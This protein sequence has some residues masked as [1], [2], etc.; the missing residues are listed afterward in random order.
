MRKKILCDKCIHH[1]AIAGSYCILQQES[2]NIC[3]ECKSFV[4]TDNVLK[5]FTLDEIKKVLVRAI[6][7]KQDNSDYDYDDNII[8]DEEYCGWQNAI[9]FIMDEL[10]VELTD[11]EV[12]EGDENNE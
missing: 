5:V 8:V 1:I 11:D 6:Y 2:S 12:L 4:E 7:K 10:G 9:H 3:T